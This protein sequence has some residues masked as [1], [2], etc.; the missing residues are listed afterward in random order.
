MTSWAA[1]NFRVYKWFW[2]CEC[3]STILNCSGWPSM[4][5]RVK[6]TANMKQQINIDWASTLATQT[7]QM[8]EWNPE[9]VF[10]G[11]AQ[12]KASNG[13]IKSNRLQYNSTRSFKCACFWTHWCVCVCVYCLCRWFTLICIFKARGPIWLILLL[14]LLWSSRRGGEVLNKLEIIYSIF[15]YC[16]NELRPQIFCVVP[17]LKMAHTYTY[18]MRALP[19]NYP[20]YFSWIGSLAT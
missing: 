6:T 12:R 7:G 14:L 19:H 3:L 15:T 4:M 2:G 16:A 9:H 1:A 5:P 8:I 13:K 17:A 11:W 18:S 10:L 20:I